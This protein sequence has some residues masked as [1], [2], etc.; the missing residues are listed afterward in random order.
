[1]KSD[2]EQVAFQILRKGQ[3]FVQLDPRHPEVIVPPWFRYQAQLTLC[4][5]Y[6][7]EP[8][9]PNLVINSIGIGGTLTFG[10]MQF[11]CL[12]PWEAIF[13]LNDEEGVGLVWPESTPTEVLTNGFKPKQTLKV[14][15]ND[16]PTL[17]PPRGRLKLVC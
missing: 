11:Y 8:D 16:N 13:G 9:I 10:G 6:N 1:M 15:T 2:K 5:G 3:L 7:I 12:M 14:H 4:V 17:S